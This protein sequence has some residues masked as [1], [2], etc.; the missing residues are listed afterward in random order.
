[1]YQQMGIAIGGS[2]AYSAMCR[3]YFQIAELESERAV[4]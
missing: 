4:A 2:N 3:S 1:M